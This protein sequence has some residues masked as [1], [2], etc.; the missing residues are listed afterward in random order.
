MESQTVLKEITEY[1]RVFYKWPAIFAI[2][3]CCVEVLSKAS[4]WWYTCDIPIGRV[5]FA[6][7]FEGVK[8]VPREPDRPVE[9]QF[10]EVKLKHLWSEKVMLDFFDAEVIH[11]YEAIPKQIIVKAYAKIVDNEMVFTDVTQLKQFIDTRISRYRYCVS[12]Q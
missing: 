3:D 9:I 2:E 1:L 6:L 10:V 7:M 8:D 5:I 4:K 11:A 12:T